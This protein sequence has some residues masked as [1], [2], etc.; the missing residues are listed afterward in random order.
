LGGE[1][2]SRSALLNKPLRT[3]VV[4]ILRDAGF[5]HVDARNGWRW[6]NDVIWVFNIRSV[7]SYFSDV[8][9]WPPGSVCAWLGVFFTFSPRPGGMKVD[10]PNPCVT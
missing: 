5:Q 1:V 4:P 7:G 6:H 9:G 10:R 8:T 3:L 2:A